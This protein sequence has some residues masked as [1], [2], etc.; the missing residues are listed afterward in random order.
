MNMKTVFGLSIAFL[1][2]GLVG[3]NDRDAASTEKTE[4]AEK[5]QSGSDTASLDTGVGKNGMALASSPAFEAS[6]G[7]M[8][9]MENVVRAETAKYLAAETLQSG[10]NTFRHE[11]QG[12]DLENQTVIRSNFDAI[13]SYGVFDISDGLTIT[14]PR[15]AHTPL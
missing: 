6:G 12:I 13:Y 14:H 4:N 11:R 7:E 10:P 3:C 15:H 8:A 9:T 1:I 2:M 5:T